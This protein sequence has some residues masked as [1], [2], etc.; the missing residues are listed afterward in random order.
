MENKIEYSKQEVPFADCLRGNHEKLLVKILQPQWTLQTSDQ[1]GVFIRDSEQPDVSSKIHAFL[2][3]SSDAHLVI[4]PEYCVPVETIKDICK[5]PQ[6]FFKED[7]T[8][9]TVFVLPIE[10]MSGADYDGLKNCFHEPGLN[11]TQVGIPTI[12][13]KFGELHSEPLKQDE[14]VNLCCILFRQFVGSGRPE[15]SHFEYHCYFQGKTFSAPLESK[16]LVLGKEIFCFHGVHA[17]LIVL[18]CADAHNPELQNGLIRQQSLKPGCILIH[19]QWNPHPD[20]H[21]IETLRNRFFNEEFGGKR[22][23]IDNNW[24]AESKIVNSSGDLITKIV[25]PRNRIFFRDHRYAATIYPDVIDAGIHLENKKMYKYGYRPTFHVLNAN[26]ESC[27]TLSMKRPVENVEMPDLS[28]GFIFQAEV[29]HFI[30]NG[31][32]QFEIAKEE[33]WN[34]PWMIFQEIASYR[35]TIREWL[36]KNTAQEKLTF[37]QLQY[38]FHSILMYQEF[39]YGYHEDVKKRLPTSL[40]T[41]PWVKKLVALYE[42]LLSDFHRN[43]D[44]LCSQLNC[45][46][47]DCDCADYKNNWLMLLFYILAAIECLHDHAKEFTL[48]CNCSEW[49]PYN[50]LAK[51]TNGRPNG[52][53]RGWVMNGRGKIRI[54]IFRQIHDVLQRKR[55]AQVSLF[56]TGVPSDCTRRNLMDFLATN[57]TI[58]TTYSEESNRGL[59]TDG[60]GVSH[61]YYRNTLLNIHL[62]TV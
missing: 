18:I 5:S 33:Q 36:L 34:E 6:S 44:I 12:H 24:A 39:D 9:N 54:Q 27:L 10:C 58:G 8:T 48:S 52:Y 31:D 16:G 20:Y 50:L 43:K 45:L 15:T 32:G 22:I 41:C 47:Q 40:V 55:P 53:H 35:P 49:Y 59:L 46:F 37:S 57:V 28:R 2:R 3:S 56:L 26:Q 42:D 19:P 7:A 21:Y 62:C 13:G 38:L 23:L 61:G 30:K 11:A 17:S 1:N 29:G 14:F 51:G 4:L 60:V 25:R